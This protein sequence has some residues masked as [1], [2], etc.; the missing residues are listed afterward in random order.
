[1]ASRV[2]HDN[3]APV[4]AGGGLELVALLLLALVL[5][6]FLWFASRIP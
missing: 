1:M 2:A 3:D 5:G 6:A 4:D